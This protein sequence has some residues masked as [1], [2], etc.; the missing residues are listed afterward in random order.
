ML[1]HPPA[2]THPPVH[3][4][5]DS[6]G[7]RNAVW[8]VVAGGALMIVA[9]LPSMSR[10]EW[11]TLITTCFLVAYSLIAVVLAGLQGGELPLSSVQRDAW[12]GKVAW[13]IPGSRAASSQ[14][15]QHRSQVARTPRPCC[16]AHHA[17]A[18]PAAGR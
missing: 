18:R 6:C 17:A 13:S 9:Q 11:A 16:C 8:T 7:V 14:G 5:A 4:P 2:S 1:R 12:A 15:V 10:A 3:P